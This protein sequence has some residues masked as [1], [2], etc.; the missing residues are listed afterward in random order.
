MYAIVRL[1]GSVNTK[2]DIKDTLDMLRL[3]RINHCVVVPDSPH[4]RGMIQ[5][6]KDYVAWGEI[7]EDALASMLEMRGRL[8]GNRRL[9]D[10]FIKEKTSYGTIKEFASALSQ[11]AVSLKDAG[12]KPVFRLHPPRKGHR[13]TKKTVK[14]GGELGYHESISDLIWKMR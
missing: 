4:Y 7:D 14:E 11:G 6:V 10:Q 9:T 5:K 1:R 2:P 8:N 13:G 3:H 12:I